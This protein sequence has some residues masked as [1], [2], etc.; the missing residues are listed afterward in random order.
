MSSVCES[1]AS[2]RVDFHVLSINAPCRS[3][4]LTKVDFRRQHVNRLS[5][6][7][8]G[9]PGRLLNPGFVLGCTV[10]ALP[11][12]DSAA[13]GWGLVPACVKAT[14]V[15][16]MGSQGGESLVLRKSVFLTSIIMGL[17][18]NHE[19]KAWGLC[20]PHQKK[21]PG[22]LCA[23]PTTLTQRSAWHMVNVQYIL[24]EGRNKGKDERNCH[25]KHETQFG[26]DFVVLVYGSYVKFKGG[27]RRPRYNS[28]GLREL[29]LLSMN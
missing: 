29:Y 25:R 12:S 21:D 17:K 7:T 14:L 15:I 24:M 4:K 22:W 26:T 10:C 8:W 19:L 6:G 9:G 20:L 2:G 11:E 5:K 3:W 16:L 23:F 18:Y 27:R 1:P 13:L 28:T